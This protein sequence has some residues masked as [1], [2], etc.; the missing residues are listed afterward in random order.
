MSSKKVQTPNWLILALAFVTALLMWYTVTVR[1]R[2]EAQLEVR[3]DYRGVPEN[4]VVVDGLINKMS[5]RLRGPEALVRSITPQNLNQVINLSKLKKGTNI[6]PLAPSE[7]EPAIRAFEIIEVSPPKLTLE[8]DNLV[9]RNVPVKPVLKSPLQGTVLTVTD[10]AVG[11]PT[12]SVRGPESLVNGMGGVKVII[13]LDPKTSA[14]THMQNLPLDVP[15][16]VSA[17]PPSVDVQYT[18]TSGRKEVTLQRT[19][20]VASQDKQRYTITPPVVSL[21]VEVPESLA[22]NNGYLNKAQLSI[23]PPPMALGASVR[24]PISLSLPEGM[25][26]LEAPPTYVT[27]TKNKK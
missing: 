7:W 9:T 17:N 27:V 4:M 3:L 23:V 25:T 10:I 19:I 14:G 22:R 6:I 5:I 18:I 20:A 1:D 8:V 12:V 13:P 16:F 11:P 21:R 24:V 2:L 15:N 26:V